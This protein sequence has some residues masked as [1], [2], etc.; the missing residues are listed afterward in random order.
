[1]TSR[2]GGWISSG[3]EALD[4]GLG[5]LDSGLGAGMEQAAGA[6]KAL[7]PSLP[8]DL[9]ML[10]Q[11]G[12]ALDLHRGFIDM[13]GIYVI[14]AQNPRDV[15]GREVFWKVGMSTNLR[16]RLSGNGTFVVLSFFCRRRR[17]CAVR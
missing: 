12:G 4:S 17:P 14:G 1:M 10:E 6:P 7:T 15:R 8:P 11:G 9:P 13:P 2:L 5:K 3:A 16:R